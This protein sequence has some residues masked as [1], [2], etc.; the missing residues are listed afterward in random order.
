MSYESEMIQRERKRKKA[1][2]EVGREGAGLL[3]DGRE[4]G[5]SVMSLFFFSLKAIVQAVGR[6]GSESSLFLL[7][8]LFPS[9]SGLSH[10]LSIE[11]K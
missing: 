7:T 11:L 6:Q 4:R 10:N 1:E 9:L 2:R 5:L 3:A 8:P